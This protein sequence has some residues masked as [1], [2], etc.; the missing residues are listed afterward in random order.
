MSQ[1]SFIYRMP[2]I[3][4][5]RTGSPGETTCQ[6]CHSDFALNSGGGFLKISTIPAIINN[7]YIPGN[8]Y[9]VNVLISQANDSIFSFDFESLDSAGNDA[10]TFLITDNVH[11]TLHTYALNNRTN[12]F[13]GANGIG[14]GNF[15]FTFNWTAPMNGAVS[16]YAAGNVS[17]A[18]GMTS[19]DYIYSDSLVHIKPN[20][21][22][23][24]ENNYADKD[25]TLISKMHKAITIIQFKVEAAIIKR[26]PH[27]DMNSRLLLNDIDY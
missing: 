14:N 12:V 10:G 24:I 5:G 2:T 3:M 26:R 8:T 15:T 9:T 27:Y 23:V 18:D 22:S 21:A 16:F 19:G 20:N 25:L 7:E 6:S 17:N 4:W 13:Y 1:S 11:T